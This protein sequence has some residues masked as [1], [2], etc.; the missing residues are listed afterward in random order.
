MARD[1]GL[2]AQILEARNILSHDG[3]D[4]QGG[5]LAE[6]GDV[7]PRGQSGRVPVRHPVQAVE[8]KVRPDIPRDATLGQGHG[9]ASIGAIVRGTEKPAAIAS[10]APLQGHRPEVHVGYAPRLL[11]SAEPALRI[12]IRPGG[13][14]VAEQKHLVTRLERDAVG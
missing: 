10:A 6:E 13:S 11:R 4:R 9:Q 14:R 2:A 12:R 3:H 8:R 1:S 5:R 7:R